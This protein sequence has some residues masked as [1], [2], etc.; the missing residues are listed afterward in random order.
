VQ[1]GASLGVALYPSGGDEPD[2]LLR[3]ADAAMYI[4]KATGSSSPRI[5]GE[6]AGDVV[7]VAALAPPARRHPLHP[8]PDRG[9]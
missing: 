4:A 7:A 1:L 9:C 2:L 6:A 5:Y 8:S 3:N